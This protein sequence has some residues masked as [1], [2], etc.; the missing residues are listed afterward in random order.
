MKVKKFFR[1]KYYRFAGEERIFSVGG[2]VKYAVGLI[3]M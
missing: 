2:E 1:I 3:Y